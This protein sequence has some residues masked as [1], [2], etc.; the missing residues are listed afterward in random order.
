M[1]KNTHNRYFEKFNFYFSKSI[2]EIL[3]NYSIPHVIYFKDFQYLDEKSEYLKRFYN[4]GEIRLRFEILTSFFANSYKET[5]PNLI[6][7]KC[8]RTIIKRNYKHACL[9]MHKLNK[10]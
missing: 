2:N 7:T 10:I 8:F 9:F 4:I 1:R 3:V 6:P 5:H